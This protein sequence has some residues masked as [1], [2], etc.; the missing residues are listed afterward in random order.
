MAIEDGVELGRCLRDLPDTA[1]AFAAY[2][3]LRRRRVERVVAFGARTSNSK[4]AGPVGRVFRDA[5][6]PIGLRMMSRQA[7]EWLH[8]YEIDWDAPVTADVP[9]GRRG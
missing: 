6:L 2:E 9:V 5:F 1:A 4:A 7:T 8:G 3:R